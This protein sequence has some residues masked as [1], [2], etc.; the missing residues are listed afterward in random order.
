[1]FPNGQY[2]VGPSTKRRRVNVACKTCRAHK[3]RCDGVRP[4]CGTCH[5]RREAC[6]YDNEE[7]GTGP[8]L[9]SVSNDKIHTWMPVDKDPEPEATAMGLA[10]RLSE[11]Q[12]GGSFFG[13]SSAISFIKRLQKTLKADGP[14]SDTAPYDT[15]QRPSD[16]RTANCLNIPLSLLPPRSLADHLVESYFTKTHVLYP[17]IH[18][19]A[20]YSLYQ[21]LWSAE[22]RASDSPINVGLGLGDSTISGTTFYYGLNIVFAMGCQFSGMLGVERE[23]TSEAFFSRCKPALDVDSLERGDL[24]LVQVLLAMSHLLQSSQT[25]NRCWHVVGSACRLA[26]G[27][28]MHASVGDERRSFAQIQMRRRIWHGCRMLDLS[29]STM[30]G[31]PAMTSHPTSVPLPKAIDDCYLVGDAICEQPPDTF[32][33]VEWYVATLKLHELL[34]KIGSALYGDID[35]GATPDA[36]AAHNVRQIQSITDIESDLDGFCLQL[37]RQLD[38]TTMEDNPDPFLREKCLLKARFLYVKIM[39]YRPALSQSFDFMRSTKIDDDSTRIQNPSESGIYSNLTLNCS[40]LCVQSAIELISLIDKTCRND[41]ASV[42]FYNIFYICTAALALVLAEFHSRVVQTVTRE[43]LDHAWNTCQ[44]ALN[45]LRLYSVVAEQC[46]YSLNDVRLRCLKMQSEHHNLNNP[47]S[48]NTLI[49]SLALDE[50]GNEDFADGLFPEIDF[51]NISFDWSWLDANY[52]S[53]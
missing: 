24:A 44:S 9:N 10:T 16:K 30:L 8:A 31:R 34:R 2:P 46:A 35:H 43:A 52:L 18:K 49:E 48:G 33:R 12:P 42:W 20:F 37:P 3:I 38:W 41:L 28:G 1:M 11:N 53:S 40:V 15:N 23:T 6:A 50:P 5:R 4:Y 47:H 22:S 19:E 25:P 13:D 14:V 17:F 27:L 51:A 29:A 45:H 32:S 39:A 26:Q 7:A 21:R 36:R